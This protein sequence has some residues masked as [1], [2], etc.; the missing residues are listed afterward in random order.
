LPAKRSED[1]ARAA[2][3]KRLGGSPLAATLAARKT[4]GPF[5]EHAAMAQDIKD[6]M[7]SHAGWARLSQPHREALD[8]IAHKV[9]RAVTGDAAYA[10][11]WHD[12]AGYAALG[13][14]ACDVK[15]A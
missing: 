7:R 13:E 3:V 15:K 8:M 12:I 9:A 6:R 2:T 4:H 1:K 11:H 14:E 5:D 10:D